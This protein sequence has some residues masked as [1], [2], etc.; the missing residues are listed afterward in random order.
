MLQGDYDRADCLLESSRYMARQCGAM[1]PLVETVRLTGE[2][3]WYRGDVATAENWWTEAL[4]LARQH[5]G[6]G[7]VA[8]VQRWLAYAACAAGDIDRAEA[9]CEK[10]LEGF[11][12]G[13]VYG[14]GVVTLAR[15][16][17]ALF[18]GD[19]LRGAVLFQQCLHDL[20][21]VRDWIDMVRALEGLA[22]A[23]AA[24]DNYENAAQLL[25]FLA[26][27]RERGGMVLPPVDQAHHERALSSARE[28]LGQE[29][30][31]AAWAAGE[32]LTLEEA[33]QVGL[34]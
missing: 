9:L 12:K 13:N 8:K 34:G 19:A 2:T 24:V 7:D 11:A 6:P 20:Q 1:M 26:A 14:S 17:I 21:L 32:A 23:V 29:A 16:R 3:A 22:W 30:F 25:G 5:A 18:R 31:A 15:A 27:Y 10:S 28:A 33:V 4:G